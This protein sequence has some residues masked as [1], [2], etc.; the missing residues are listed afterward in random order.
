MRKYVLYDFQSAEIITE[1]AKRALETFGTSRQERKDFEVA[2]HIL[3]CVRAASKLI[4]ESQSEDIKQQ[5]IDDLAI[6]L[7]N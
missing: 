4:S 6:K 1:R 5:A 7:F 2:V 3:A